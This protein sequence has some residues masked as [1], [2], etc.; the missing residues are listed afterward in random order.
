VQGIG[1]DAK[2]EAGP[3]M[4]GFCACVC[5]YVYRCVC[6]YVRVCA[7]MRQHRSRLGFFQHHPQNGLYAC[8]GPEH[9]HTYIRV[10]G[11]KSAVA[12]EGAAIIYCSLI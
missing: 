11:R 6:L 9:I 7:C 3:N 2:G 10:C 8:S 4:V 5:V 12:R 1:K